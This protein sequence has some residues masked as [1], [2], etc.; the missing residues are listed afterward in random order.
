MMPGWEDK[1]TAETKKIEE[2]FRKEFPH[3]DAYRFN[4][5]AIR[6]RIIDERFE[7][8]SIEEREAMAWHLLDRLPKRTRED[9][10]L[11]LTLAPSEQESFNR[12]TLVN[13]EFEQPLLSQ[14]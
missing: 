7:G 9:V 5:A 8:K 12:H 11:L 4:S 14:F 13:Q 1:R 10:M 3:T 2:I 6:I